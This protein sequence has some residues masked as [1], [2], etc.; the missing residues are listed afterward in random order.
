MAYGILYDFQQIM[1]STQIMPMLK[2]EQHKFSTK[3]RSY[4]KIPGVRKVT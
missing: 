3:S 1:S 2:P 4:V